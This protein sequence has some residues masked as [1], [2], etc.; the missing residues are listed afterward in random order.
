MAPGVMPD[1][2]HGG[3]E[4]VWGAELPFELPRH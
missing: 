4:Q 2:E 3:R 1:T